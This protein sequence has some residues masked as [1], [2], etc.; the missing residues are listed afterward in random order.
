MHALLRSHKLPLDGFDGG[1]V[2][3]LVARDGDRIVGSAAL[4]IYEPYALLRSVAVDDQLRG[5]GLGQL[6]TAE[7]IALAR[8]KNLRAVYLLTE[9]AAGFFPKLGFQPVARAEIPAAV[10]QSVE[11]TSACPASAAALMLRL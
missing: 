8:R 6:L 10:Q 11:F 4:E 3:A 5:R 1:N 2:A 9:T 7:A